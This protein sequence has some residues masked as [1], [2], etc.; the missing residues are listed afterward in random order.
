MK[1]ALFALLI[2]ASSCTHA[3][4]PEISAAR[5]PSSAGQVYF[6]TESVPSEAQALLLEAAQGRKKI[7]AP[8]AAAAIEAYAGSEQLKEILKHYASDLYETMAI[9]PDRSKE[10]IEKNGG[11]Y[12]GISNYV[13]SSDESMADEEVSWQSI[14]RQLRNGE[15]MS[16]A[17]KQFLDEILSSLSKMPVASG[18]AF[19][20]VSMTKEFFA[21]V[22]DRGPWPQKAFTSTSLHPMVAHG[23]GSGQEGYSQRGILVLKLKRGYPVSPLTFDHGSMGQPGRFREYELLLPPGRTLFVHGKAEDT[24]TQ[25]YYVFAEE[26]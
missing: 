15:K 26:R 19:R 16:R 18:L 3:P 8:E 2:A 12:K 10:W 22:P 24:A 7:S 9:D 17:E 5:Q 20:G 1:Y 21:A 11:F 6:N 4:L 13:G 14:N 25:T 23:F